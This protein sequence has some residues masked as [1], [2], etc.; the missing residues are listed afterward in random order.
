MELCITT[1]PYKCKYSFP[2]GT[3]FTLSVTGQ[4]TT[5]W[6]FTGSGN[7]GTIADATIT[8]GAVVL[9]SGST[10]DYEAATSH[11]FVIT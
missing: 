11:I 4:T 6:A 3:L 7:P 5:T 2:I 9:A 10:L 8:N 1:L